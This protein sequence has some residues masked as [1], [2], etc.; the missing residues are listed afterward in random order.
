MGSEA[1][2]DPRPG[3]VCRIRFDD[4]GAAM[5]RFVEVEPGRRIVF[6]WGWE[7]RWLQVPPQSTRVE[8][9]FV[10]DGD[11]TIVRLAHTDLPRHAAEFHRMGWR[12]YMARLTVAATG[13]D[14][15]A[16]QLAASLRARR[17]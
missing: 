12:H 5:G 9:T 6:T 11:G 13:A 17:S 4:G 14:P 1:T 16:D 10:P 2:L 8:V 15:G 3:G 7:A